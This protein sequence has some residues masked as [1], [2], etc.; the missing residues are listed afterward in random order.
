MDDNVVD[1][2]TGFGSGTCAV[3]AVPASK[4]QTSTLTEAVILVVYI[5]SGLL[6]PRVIDSCVDDT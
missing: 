4:A 2:R 1:L 5:V 3:A 6:D